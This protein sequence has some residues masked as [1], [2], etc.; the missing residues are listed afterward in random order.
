VTA[1]DSDSDWTAGIPAGNER[2]QADSVPGGWY[3]TAGEAGSASQA[4]YSDQA[5]SAPSPLPGGLTPGSLVPGMDVRSP[6]MDY[7]LGRQQRRGRRVAA[8]AASILAIGVVAAVAVTVAHNGSKNAGG[9]QLTAAQVVQQ[10]TR[11][12][13]GL[14]SETATISEHISG[15]V[16]AT[17][18]GTVE[19]QRKPLLMAMNV[20]VTAGGN[21]RG[22]IRGIVSDKAMY[23]KLSGAAGLPKNLAGKWLKIPLTGLSPSSSFGALQQE[24]QNENPASQFAELKAASHLRAAGTQVVSGV[25]TTRYTGSFT[26]A[27]AVKALP[28]AQRA[29]LA[30]Y[31]H[32]IKSDVAFSVWIDSSHYVRKFQETESVGGV[33]VALDCTFGSFNQ[34]VNIALPSP[35]QV[36]SPPASALSA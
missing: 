3:P 4:A 24:L 34:P 30:P 26:P 15:Q 27:A 5:E 2:P 23:L 35:R 7:M 18:S 16:D 29:A 11:Q 33:T 25:T 14:N 12:Q 19:V 32:L 21:H 36:Y 20:N 13:N 28:A 31:L 8:V 6:A 22:A 1:N 10:A 17:V 9:A